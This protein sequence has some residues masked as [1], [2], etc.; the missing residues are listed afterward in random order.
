M[1]KCIAGHVGFAE[2]QQIG[3]ITFIHG[4]GYRTKKG[5]LGKLATAL[6]SKY[7]EEIGF[8]NELN[9]CCA[10][11]IAKDLEAKYCSKCRADI[12]RKTI[13]PGDYEDHIRQW[14]TSTI[15]AFGSVEVLS[16]GYEWIPWSGISTIIS[17]KKNEVLD[18]GEYLERSLVAAVPLNYIPEDSREMFINYSEK[19]FYNQETKKLLGHII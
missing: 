2:S 8:N 11:T 6:F 18:I 3:L 17:L 10:N 12:N 14:F 4:I 7:K 19:V 16:D 13:D 9:S 5:A 1:I 15:D